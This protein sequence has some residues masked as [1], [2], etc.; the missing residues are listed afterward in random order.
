MDPWQRFRIPVD[1]GEGETI[2]E[3]QTNARDWIATPIDAQ[4]PM[5]GTLR[6]IHAALLRTGQ[7]V[8]RHFM[9]FLDVVLGPPQPAGEADPEAL[10]PTQ[11]DL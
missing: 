3:V 11:P 6:V 2:M 9:A 5:D 7:P 4:R 1:C 10:D 8:P